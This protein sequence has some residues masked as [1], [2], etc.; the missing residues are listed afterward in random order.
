MY[1]KI[2][3]PITQLRVN[4]NSLEGK[5][6]LNNYVQKGGLSYLW[7]KS[8]QKNKEKRLEEKITN[9]KKKP[10]VFIFGYGSIINTE[11]RISTGGKDIGNAIPVEVKSNAGLERVWNFQK[12]HIAGLTA[13]GIQKSVN[14]KF[15]DE[16]N[17]LI[18][19]I[20]KYEKD[21]FTTG[22]GKPING[23]LYP[24]Y[25]NIEKF[26]EREEGY[27][28]LRLR[29]NQLKELSW[30]KLPDY[31]C[32]IYIYCLPEENQKQRPTFDL[33]ILQ[34]YVDVVI[35]GCL[36][37]GE[38][39]AINFIKNTYGWSYAWLNDRV[40]PRRPW[41]QEPN[42]K[43]ID[44]LLKLHADG[45]IHSLPEDYVNLSL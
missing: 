21:V 16:D 14:T 38:E 10:K 19:D 8:L 29:N 34:S 31:D 28:R 4:I 3:N 6:I 43:I 17:T 37:Y 44:R 45:Y 11:S 32:K 7:K 33:P 22:K 39:F 25:D 30:Q 24:I 23:V 40:K 42:F 41:L 15:T 5:N 18:S 2:I 36:E 13:L 35:N 27:F 9:I 20:K 26:D 12:P 1:Q